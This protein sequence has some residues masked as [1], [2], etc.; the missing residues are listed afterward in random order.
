MVVV[1]VLFVMVHLLALLCH[2]VIYIDVHMAAL[3]AALS[4]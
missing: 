4:V 1:A 2:P 3:H